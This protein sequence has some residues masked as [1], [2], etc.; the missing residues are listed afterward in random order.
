MSKGTGNNFW[1]GFLN[2]LVNYNILFQVHKIKKINTAIIKR[3][4]IL[5]IDIFL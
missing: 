2:V 4:L 1:Y 3:L 5:M